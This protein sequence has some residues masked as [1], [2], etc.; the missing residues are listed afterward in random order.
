MNTVANLKLRRE[1]QTDD[2]GEKS[3]EPVPGQ[4]A[5]VYHEHLLL[6]SAGLWHTLTAEDAALRSHFLLKVKRRRVFF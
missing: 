1:F 3:F 6:G 4:S 2:T 5:T